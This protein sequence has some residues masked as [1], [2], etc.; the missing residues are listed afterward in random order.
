MIN[1]YKTAQKQILN[2]YDYLK[3]EKVNWE[4][5]EEFLY[6]DRVIEVNIPVKMDNWDIKVFTWYRSQHKN[7]KW[8]YKWWIRF[9]QD[10]TKD[11]VKALSIRM[12]VKTWVVNLPLW[13]WKWWI[14][15]NPKE[16]SLNELEQLSR[17]YVRQLYRYLW[18][19]FDIP[20]PDVNTNQQIMA[21]M[22][23]EYSKLVWKWSPWAFTWKPLALWG[24]KW[25][26]IAT[27]LWWLYVI[28]KIFEENKL[29]FKDKTV[30]IQWAWNAWLNFAKLIV[31]KWA[32][33]VAISDS[34][35]WIVNYNWLNINEI[36]ELK[37]NKQPVGDLSNVDKVSN[38]ELLELEC[39]ILVLAALENQI[40]E[41]NAQNIKAKY[42]LE[43]A[44]WP[45]TPKA[46][47]ILF[48]NNILV[49]PDILAN[50]WWVT[51]SYFEQVQWNIN[52]YWEEKE[53]FERLKA[54]MYQATKEVLNLSWKLNID[55]R[56]ASYTISLERQFNAWKYLK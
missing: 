36:E 27:A 38:T 47:E 37:E 18:E 30:V 3:K 28:E 43:L 1:P 50:A 56:K 13:G 23:D 8:P 12:S 33:V 11:E 55:L 39:D 40:T 51:V 16:L 29:D 48:K 49:V 14:I 17:W 31:Q 26:D 46:D 45:T 4:F 20:A 32:K 2:V 7:Y 54:I 41:E 53:V 10:V 6:P 44:N 22:V 42:I 15:V 19:D 24:S 35:G 21:W 52:Y 9:H 25:R 34:K 5:V